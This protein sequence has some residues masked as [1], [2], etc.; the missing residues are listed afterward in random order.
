[1]SP[2]SLAQWT[3]ASDQKFSAVLSYFY[4]YFI[5]LLQNIW[6][7]PGVVTLLQVFISSLT[8]SFLANHF[9]K[10]GI[11]KYGIAFCFTL[12]VFSPVIGVYNVTIWKDV[13]FAQVIMLIGVIWMLDY[14]KS[15]L[16]YI[17]L[18]LIA[19]LTILA[20]LFRHNG[21]IYLL[22]VP[23]LYILRFYKTGRKQIIF[24]VAAIA[25][26][27]IFLHLL[28]PKI[29]YVDYTNITFLQRAGRVQMIA[30]VVNQNEPLTDD[31]RLLVENIM[32]LEEMKTRYDCSVVDMLYL[33]DENGERSFNFD[34]L[35]DK[36]VDFDN[37]SVQI[38]G[39]NLPIVLGDR[40][41]LAS[42]MMGLGKADKAYL[43][44]ADLIKNKF[45]YHQNTS[46]IQG[47][48]DSYLQ[49]STIFPQRAFYW[50]HLTAL[51]VYIF[52]GCLGLYKR[53]Y[54]LLGFLAIILVNVPM[55]FAVAAAR[56]YRY[57]Y[58]LTYAL[59]FLPL[60]Y[61]YTTQEQQ[62]EKKNRKEKTQELN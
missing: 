21:I 57:L 33:R 32:P 62:K 56:D 41:C 34:Y 20:S 9:Y 7:S 14:N 44:H 46:E 30:A 38:L 27:Y 18:L 19:I 2:D 28:L 37:I 16:S 50:T 17:T 1:M 43:Y 39:E 22:V 36:S 51:G 10:S 60:V 26:L 61:L 4:T 48:L 40:V 5:Y 54:N 52:V 23:G 29:V 49:W 31:Q 53:N 24:L 25:V 59:Y 35:N 11:N 3:S 42:H 55:I 15:K 12:F 58:M 45:D 8:V 13:L 47:L 6:N